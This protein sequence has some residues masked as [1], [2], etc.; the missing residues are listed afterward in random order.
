MTRSNG[1]KQRQ[2]TA[3]DVKPGTAEGKELGL[4]DRVQGHPS[5]IPGGRPH[6]SNAPAVRHTV[7]V[8]PS[9]PEIGMGNAHGVQPGSHT[10]AERADAERGP[11]SVH[12]TMPKPHHKAQHEKPAPI[13]V[14]VVQD[15]RD[16]VL[17]T[18]APHAI[19]VPVSTA[20]PVRLCGRDA[21][22][23]EVM[24]L[25]EST[26]TDVRFAQRPSD[27]NAGGGALLPWPGNSYLKVRTQ[28]ELWALSASGTAASVSII[29]VFERGL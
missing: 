26:V 16:E 21:G 14:Y 20:D 25:N 12:A 8:P 9:D 11:N 13:P 3:E 15:A 2:P 27:L 7:P 5:P 17:R 23:S 6:L 18:A 22:R 10:N 4:S 28:D 1:R 29:Q 24:L 19:T